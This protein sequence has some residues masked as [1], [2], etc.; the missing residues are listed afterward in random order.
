[1]AIRVVP[2]ATQ[3]H[4]Q[5]L[6]GSLAPILASGSPASSFYLRWQDGSV[7]IEQNSFTGVNTAQVDAA[8]AAAPAH[9]AALDAK[10]EIDSWGPALKAALLVV[11]DEVNR[12]RVQPT[13][14]FTA[15]TATQFMNAIKARVDT[16]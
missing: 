13:T 7:V 12:V 2:R 15:Y 3:P 5:T 14:A 11:M 16:L 1:M 6:A 10:A 8:V 4:L 9:T